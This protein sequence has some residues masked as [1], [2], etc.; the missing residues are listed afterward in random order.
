PWLLDARPLPGVRV[1]GR[2]PELRPVAH[3]SPTAVEP[4]V[5]LLWARAA[6]VPAVPGLRPTVGPV[7]GARDGE[8]AGGDRAEASRPRGAADGLGHDVAAGLAPAR[9]RRLP[10]RL[11]PHSGRHADDR[12]GARLP[13]RHA[14]RRGERGR[15]PALAGLPRGRADVSA[16][17]SSSGAGG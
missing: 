14:R 7:P 8:A 15:R 2:L 11:D 16:P 1:R 3:V 17:C 4:S 13:E 5:P 9:P 10:R 12:E 6:A